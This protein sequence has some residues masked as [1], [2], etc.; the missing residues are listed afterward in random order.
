MASRSSPQPRPCWWGAKSTAKVSDPSRPSPPPL[1]L[2]PSA[3]PVKTAPEFPE[4]MF[5]VVFFF[6]SLGNSSCFTEPDLFGQGAGAENAR[7]VASPCRGARARCCAPAW[8]RASPVSPGWR[9][10]GVQSLSAAEPVAEAWD[11]AAPQLCPFPV[12][13]TAKPWTA[14]LI[15]HG[16]PSSTQSIPPSSLHSTARQSRA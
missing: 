14:E 12:P 7:R 10:P 9:V 11:E 3:S 6:F 5:F 2:T 16:I 1:P 13:G 15:F 4:E 8:H